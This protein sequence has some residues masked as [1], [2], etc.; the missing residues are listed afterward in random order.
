M[1]MWKEKSNL[2]LQEN[3]LLRTDPRGTLPP[4]EPDLVLAGSTHMVSWK[5]KW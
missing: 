1:Q 3:L 5:E 2:P 4:P